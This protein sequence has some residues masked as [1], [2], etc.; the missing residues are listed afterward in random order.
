M[1]EAWPDNQD[2]QHSADIHDEE[3]RQHREDD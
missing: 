2:A 3:D 1:A